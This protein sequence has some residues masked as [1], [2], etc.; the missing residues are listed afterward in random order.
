MLLFTY[1]AQ[2]IRPG[3]SLNFRQLNLS[4]SEQKTTRSRIAA[5]F[6]FLIEAPITAPAP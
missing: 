2:G 1:L 6:S 5:R 4:S 3:S